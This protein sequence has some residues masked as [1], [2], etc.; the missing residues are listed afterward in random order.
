MTDVYSAFGILN[1]F[2]PHRPDG[3]Y[4]LKLNVYEERIVCK[5][6]C[7]LSR[8]EGW[9]NLS[10]TKLN[11]KPLDVNNDFIS[12]MPE[13]GA[14]EGT[15]QCPKEKAKEDFRQKLGMKYLDWKE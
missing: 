12:E 6:L 14:F 1:L 5:I 8:A 10:N 7:E 13:T 9:A 2:S 11:G 4:M 15:Y 3:S